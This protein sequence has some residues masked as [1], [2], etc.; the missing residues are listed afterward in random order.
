MSQ[1]AGSRTLAIELSGVVRRSL[2]RRCFDIILATAILTV[3]APLLLLAILAIVIESPGSPFFLQRRLGLGGQ[4]FDIIKLRT[5]IPNA[6]GS[7]GPTLASRNDPRITAVGW[8]LRRTHVDELPQ[9]MNVLRG[10][11]AIVGPR[12]ERPELYADIIREVPDYGE[13]LKVE[14]GITGLAQTRG[15]YHLSFRNKLRYDHLYIQKQSFV[16]DL[17]IVAATILTVITMR[18][19]V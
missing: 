18:G 10:E 12:P 8:F 2:P 7:C 19:S 3:T 6:E 1:A 4:P 14:P 5:M 17:K 11:M 16:F 13:R 15:D 9:F